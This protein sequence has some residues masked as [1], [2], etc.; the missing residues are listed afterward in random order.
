MNFQVVAVIFSLRTPQAVTVPL[1]FF[2]LSNTARIWT[3]NDARCSSVSSIQTARSSV[4][5]GTAP[6]DSSP[7]INQSVETFK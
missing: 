5:I 7:N 6:E 3:R 2:L 4:C 1:F